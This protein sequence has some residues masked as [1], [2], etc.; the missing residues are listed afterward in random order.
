MITKDQQAQKDH[1][2][3]ESIK[4]LEYSAVDRMRDSQLAEGERRDARINQETEA[5]T[6]KVRDANNAYAGQ[7]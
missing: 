5:T 6:M 2:R 4:H 1:A 7:E 3:Y